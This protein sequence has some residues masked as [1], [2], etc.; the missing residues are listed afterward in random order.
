MGNIKS[1]IGS[2]FS[3]QPATVTIINREN[4]QQLIGLTMHITEKCNFSCRHCYM[5]SNPNVQDTLNEEDVFSVIDQ[6]NNKQYHATGILLSGGEPFLHQDLDSIIKYASKRIKPIIVFTNGYWVS[7]IE[8]TKKRLR[9]LRKLGCEHIKFSI[10]DK[11]HQEFIGEEKRKVILEIYQKPEKGFPLIE[12]NHEKD[13]V[14]PRGNALSLP[15]EALKLN[16]DINEDAYEDWNMPFYIPCK[17]AER[18]LFRK[19]DLTVRATG[20]VYPCGWFV[21]S[22]GNI[23]RDSI[24]SIVSNF[25]NDKD[26]ES[27]VKQG[28]HAI[29]RQRGMPEEE[30]HQRFLES[31]CKLCHDLYNN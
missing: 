27:I 20:E 31:P 30:I 16:D 29:A 23:K 13:E 3:G 1:L 19:A 22:L 15:K 10:N 28:P 11:Y 26:Y 2:N 5:S 21:K 25:W 4:N 6:L 7:D 14:D 9:E 18:D 17:L 12:L 8:K 24:D